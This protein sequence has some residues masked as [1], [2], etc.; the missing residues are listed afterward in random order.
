ME[1]GNATWC[2]TENGASVSLQMKNDALNMQQSWDGLKIALLWDCKCA[3]DV[4]HRFIKQSFEAKRSHIPDL[5][6][7]HKLLEPAACGGR[8]NC[9][10]ALTYNW[11]KSS[12]EDC[13][14]L[15]FT[16]WHFL[17]VI[18]NIFLHFIQLLHTK[19]CVVTLWQCYRAHSLLCFGPLAE[20][21]AG[22][23]CTFCLQG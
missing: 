19:A 4:I 18:K 2:R 14:N 11:R 17:F 15:T 13:C 22:K 21:S 16:F 7:W 20:L 9:S 12:I 8:G 3:S 1:M 6:C 23:L 5:K 10:P